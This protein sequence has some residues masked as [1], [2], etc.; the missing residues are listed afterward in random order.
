MYVPQRRAHR[1]VY[2]EEEALRTSGE[3][4]KLPAVVGTKELVSH[5]ARRRAFELSRVGATVTA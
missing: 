5:D 4:R 2:L 1:Q 3:E